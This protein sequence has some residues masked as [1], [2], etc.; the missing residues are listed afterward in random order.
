MGIFLLGSFLL[1][2]SV[3]WEFK[4]VIVWCRAIFLLNTAYSVKQ[5]N[6]YFLWV[7]HRKTSGIQSPP[8]K[9]YNLVRWRIWI[10]IHLKE[11]TKD[12][13]IDQLHD[14]G[15]TSPSFPKDV[16][17]FLRGVSSLR[18]IW[19]S[20]TKNQH[21]LPFSHQEQLIWVHQ[22]FVLERLRDSWSFG[23]VFSV[24]LHL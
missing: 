18:A 24:F 2:K 7:H 15:K 9:V 13:N 10:F 19:A 23:S 11:V 17:T 12:S 14:M 8:Q 3:R 21:L 1:R 4:L 6:N 20:I 5:N 16:C 22:P